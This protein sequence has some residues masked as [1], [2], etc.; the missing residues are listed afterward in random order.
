M[1]H[2]ACPPAIRPRDYTLGE[3]GAFH[4]HIGPFLVLGYRIGRYVRDHFCD[5]PFSISARVCCPARS[6]ERCM[7]DGI[8]VSSGCT[9]GKE[10][11]VVIDDPDVRAEFE[12]GGRL[13]VIRPRPFPRP[14]RDAHYRENLLRCAEDF[15]VLPDAELFDVS[16]YGRG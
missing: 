8:Q 2:S 10:N 4:A 6:P 5:D 15:F 16:R 3:L 12:A 1:V 7:V 14:V 11:I 13:I 9:L